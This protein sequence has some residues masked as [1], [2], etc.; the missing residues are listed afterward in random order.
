MPDKQTSQLADTTAKRTAS[1]SM[2][3]GVPVWCD[4]CSCEAEPYWLE[5]FE[6]AHEDELSDKIAS[7]HRHT[8]S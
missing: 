7:I 2:H 5:A 8:E 1:K 6:Q 4:C 3:D